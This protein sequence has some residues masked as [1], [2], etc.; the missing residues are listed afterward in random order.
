ME[1]HN[2]EPRSPLEPADQEL[3][4]PDRT[5]G[6]RRS[7]PDRRHRSTRFW[8][9]LLGR[10]QRRDGRRTEDRDGLYVDVYR[11][12]DVLLLAGIF[13]F[14][15]FDAFFTLRWLDMGG[16]E[17][18]PLMAK[19]LEGGDLIFLIQKCF[20]VGVWLVILIVHKNFRVARTGLWS[21]LAIYG[22][23]LLYHL[24]HVAVQTNPVLPPAS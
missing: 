5:G 18:N 13:L 6:D 15:I 2:L 4:S 17:A 22:L 9:S 11:R 8:D 7:G 24:Y 10:R 1:A 20:V 19:L 21:L 12:R 3:G 23:L 16:G 14:N